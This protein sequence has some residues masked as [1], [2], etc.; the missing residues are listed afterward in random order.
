MIPSGPGAEVGFLLWG[1]VLMC[2]ER[3]GSKSKGVETGIGKY[4]NQIRAS[5]STG[6]GW[7]YFS[8]KYVLASSSE[9]V[10]PSGV[11]SRVPLVQFFFFKL[12]K[13]FP[14]QGFMM[15]GGILFMFAFIEFLEV[16]V[17]FDGLSELVHF[18][19]GAVFTKGFC[20]RHFE[21][22]VLSLAP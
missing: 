5:K 16:I 8:G 14:V 9:K 22:H 19:F 21:W 4:G 10:A 13:V 3:I 20:V 18:F 7:L 2:F 12:V 6:F 17:R 15:A 1:T 11:W